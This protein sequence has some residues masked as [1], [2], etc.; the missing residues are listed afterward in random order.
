MSAAQEACPVGWHIPSDVEWKELDKYLRLP[1]FTEENCI[2]VD[3]GVHYYRWDPGP[4]IITKPCNHI[5]N[6]TEENGFNV[7]LGGWRY[8]NGEFERLNIATKWWSNSYRSYHDVYCYGRFYINRT[9]CYNE[10]GIEYR[11]GSESCCLSLRCIKDEPLPFPDTLHKEINSIPYP[12]L[13]ESIKRNIKKLFMQVVKDPHY[14]YLA[15]IDCIIGD[16]YDFI[17][18][19]W[20]P[21]EI[22]NNLS[23][24]FQN[25]QFDK[26]YI[27]C[28]VCIYSLNG[29]KSSFFNECNARNIDDVVELSYNLLDKLGLVGAFISNGSQAID[30]IN[31]HNI[32]KN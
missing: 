18:P 11:L 4:I 9:L 27:Y 23:V 8:E 15:V 6:K 20:I 25:R 16:N 22:N 21:S 12:M 19:Q 26:E 2:A 32:L 5:N 1:D 28:I 7:S 3:G 30:Y 31:K 17:R 10:Y 29:I 14:N 13:K 24:K